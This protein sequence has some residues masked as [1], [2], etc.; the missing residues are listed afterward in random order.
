MAPQTTS[1]KTILNKTISTNAQSS[2]N[3][4]VGGKVLFGARFTWTF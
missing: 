2:L 3:E 4:S 1:R